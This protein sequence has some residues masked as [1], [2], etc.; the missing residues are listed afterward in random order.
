MLISCVCV[1][2]LL[3][4]AQ[5]CQLIGHG[6]LKHTMHCFGFQ[7][8]FS[9][10]ALFIKKCTLYC[11]IKRVWYYKHVSTGMSVGSFLCAKGSVHIYCINLRSA[12]AWSSNSVTSVAYHHWLYF[13]F[14]IFAHV[15]LYRPC[16][17]QSLC[18]WKLLRKCIVKLGLCKFLCT[19]QS[20]SKR[21]CIQMFSGPC[22]KISLLPN[23]FAEMRWSSKATPS[24]WFLPNR[25]AVLNLAD[26]WIFI[27]D[28]CMS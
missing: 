6:K 15:F 26:I 24:K 5:S 21:W 17:M 16:G 18:N 2:L 14:K 20:L 10:I 27:Y 1:V 8:R 13:N 19:C 7:S 25:I 28:R 23:I 12:T 11:S 9:S 22:V 4:Y 3:W